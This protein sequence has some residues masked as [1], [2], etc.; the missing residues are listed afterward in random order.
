MNN[1]WDK[2]ADSYVRFNP[3]MTEFEK[4]FYSKLNEWKIDFSSKSIIDI[5]CGSGVH[6]LRIAQSANHVLALDGSARM[7]EILNNDA[8]R[9]DLGSK[10]KTLHCN[11][12]D[13]NLKP[14]EFDLAFSTMSPAICDSDSF[15]KFILSSPLHIYLGWEAPRYSS[16]LEPFFEFYNAKPNNMRCGVK[17]K[18][19]LENKDINFKHM[20][21]NETRVCIR[22]FKQA[23]ENICWHLEISNIDFNKDEVFDI[24]KSKFPNTEKIEEK[25]QSL[26][27]LLVF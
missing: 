3:D 4:K 24:L 15:E 2:K 5:G 9:L 13:Y 17:L 16:L 1:I 21:F 14:F 26:M 20:S 23:L 25:I 10:I 8:N 11:W 7:L 22:S 18:E 19:Y 27:L 6:T 12:K